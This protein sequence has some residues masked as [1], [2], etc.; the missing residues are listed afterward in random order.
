MYNELF[1]IGNVTIYSYGVCIGIGI[2][3]GFLAQYFIMKRYKQEYQRAV[4]MVLLAVTFGFVGAKLNFYI[5]N[6]NDIRTDISLLNPF[7]EG[8][9]I[10]GGVIAGMITVL[11]Y[12]K[13]NKL[14]IGEYMD[15]SIISVAIAQTIGRIG[16]FM[17]GCC[18]GI[19]YNGP[20]SI[21]FK[22]SQFAPNNVS[23]LP[24]QLIFSFADFVN[25]CILLIYKKK[26][27]IAGRTIALYMIN[28]GLGRFCLEYIRGDSVRGTILGM[29][30]AQFTSIFMCIIGCLLY[31][32]ITT[33]YNKKIASK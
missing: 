27:K 28:Y 29:S 2:F 33:Q 13:I 12:C 4:D 16:C 25:F 30:T 18:Y 14:N 15:T 1:N 6:L 17:S 23:L 19:S 32:I 3:A 5:V 9:V 24:T 26:N 11:L 22:N 7:H 31:G 21:T 10:Y 20:F 8:L